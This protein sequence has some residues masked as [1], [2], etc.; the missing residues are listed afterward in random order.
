MMTV[1]RQWKGGIVLKT[2]PCLSIG[3]QPL[4]RPQPKLQIP[5]LSC[6]F[7]CATGMSA[8]ANLCLN[9]HFWTFEARKTHFGHATQV[10]VHVAWRGRGPDPPLYLHAAD[11][12]ARH[13]RL[14]RCGHAGGSLR[15]ARW[16]RPSGRA[17]RRRSRSG[18]GP[19]LQASERR[20]RR[21]DPVW[22]V[23]A[24]SGSFTD[25]DLVAA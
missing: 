15:T 14:A 23:L 20:H 17:C 18:V 19:G 13:P 25:S 4:I 21:D 16:Q 12:G 24:A 3:A 9:T 6:F 10:C 1:V 11:Q 22:M 5:V 2:S 7:L 8:E